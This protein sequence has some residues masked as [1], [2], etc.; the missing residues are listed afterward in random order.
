MQKVADE[1]V[2]GLDELDKEDL[3]WEVMHK[4]VLEEMDLNQEILEQENCEWKQF[5]HACFL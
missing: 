1:I 2:L 3:N 5:S 4:E